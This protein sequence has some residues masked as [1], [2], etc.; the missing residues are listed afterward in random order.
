MSDFPDLESTLVALQPAL[1]SAQHPWW[2][3]GSAAVALISGKA[4]VIRDVDVLFDPRD[5][6][7]ILRRLGLVPLSV[8][9]DD[10]FK[11]AVFAKWNGAALPVELFA[12]FC[13]REGGTWSEYVPQSRVAVTL[14]EAAAF[15]P[16]RAELLALL[17]RF[18][19]PKD[20]ARAALL[21]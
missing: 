14:G 17:H 7:A 5:A 11:S 3:L 18:G 6:E 9:A 2:V 12:G 1:A 20:L 4:D 10:Q 21:T 19:R 16:E 15:V 13:L 8:A